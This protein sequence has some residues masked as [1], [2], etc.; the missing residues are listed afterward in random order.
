MDFGPVF[1]KTSSL[2]T[3]IM[4]KLSRNINTTNI[5][6]FRFNS[7]SDEQCTLNICD[8]ECRTQ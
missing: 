7:D 1:L 6:E 8:T 5:E 3:S 4:A 2:A